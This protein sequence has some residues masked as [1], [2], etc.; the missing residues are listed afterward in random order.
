[1]VS[2]T[3][4]FSSSN[5]FTKFLNVVVTKMKCGSLN[6]IWMKEKIHLKRKKEVDD[7]KKSQQWSSISCEYALILRLMA[8]VRKRASRKNGLLFLFIINNDQSGVATSH[9][10]GEKIR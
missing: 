2:S 6:T 9:G 1:M 5:V 10:S 7:N 3:I 8:L 4:I